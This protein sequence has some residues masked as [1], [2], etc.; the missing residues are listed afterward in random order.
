MN[1]TSKHQRVIRISVVLPV[2]VELLVGNDDDKPN[3]E[4]DWQILAVR[5]ASCEATRQL[6]EENMSGED[7]EELASAAAKA[8]DQK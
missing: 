2:S 1:R 3:T 6:V 7:F 4:S 5:S 8:K